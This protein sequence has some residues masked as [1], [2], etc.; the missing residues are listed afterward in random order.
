MQ[1]RQN[2]TIMKVV[3]VITIAVVVIGILAPFLAVA[4]R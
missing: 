1:N 4:G 2:K 3:V